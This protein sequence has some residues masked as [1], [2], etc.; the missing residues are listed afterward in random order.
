MRS[1]MDSPFSR[2]FSISTRSFTPSTTIWTSSTSEKPR[3]SAL[4]ISNTPPTAAVSTPP[5]REKKI[6]VENFVPM[7]DPSDQYR[8][9]MGR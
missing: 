9:W 1:S 5:E 8:G 6:K 3:R 4:E 7:K 2:H